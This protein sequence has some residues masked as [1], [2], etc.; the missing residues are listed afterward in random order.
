M[1]LSPET[2]RPFLHSAAGRIELQVVK[3]CDSTNLQLQNLAKAGAPSGTLL[4]A[5]RQTAGR[6]R[7][8][9]SWYQGSQSLAF[10]LLWKL[11]EDR[12][13]SGLSLAVGLAIAE[14][15][16]VAATETAQLKWPNDVLINGRKVAGIL[17]E[18]AGV[19]NASP[20]YVIGIGINL[21]STEDLPEEVSTIAGAVSNTGA[22]K[23][24]TLAQILDS[25]VAVLDEF[26]MHGFAPLQSRWQSRHAYQDMAVNLFFSEGGDPVQGVCRG[27]DANGELLLETATCIQTIASGEL[28]LPSGELSLPSGEVSLRLQ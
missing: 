4:L 7:R 15:L 2:L 14:A 9:R 21:G 10:S 20:R 26:S 23:V 28:S 6:G 17:I 25:L 19:H 11:P 16:P 22:D 18:S 1:S 24:R 5:E 13:P 8:G 27:V 3:E 12:P